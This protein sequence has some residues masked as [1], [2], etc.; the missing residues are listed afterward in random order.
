MNLDEI[1]SYLDLAIVIRK[2]KELTTQNSVTVVPYHVC[3]EH[4][5]Y[6]AQEGMCKSPAN[7]GLWLDALQLGSEELWQAAVTVGF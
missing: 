5:G 3:A 6:K 2:K 7:R 1:D 4:L